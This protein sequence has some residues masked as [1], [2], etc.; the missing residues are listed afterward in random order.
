MSEY[1]LVLEQGLMWTVRNHPV[2]TAV[3][4]RLRVGAVWVRLR[5]KDVKL[6]RFAD[7]RA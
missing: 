3:D 7:G 4:V 6:W 1:T 5:A 2:S